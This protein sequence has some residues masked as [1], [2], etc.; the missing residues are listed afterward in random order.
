MQILT[1]NIGA[2]LT[3]IEIVVLPALLLRAKADAF[4]PLRSV[5]QIAHHIY[6]TLLQLFQEITKAAIYI[7]IAPIGIICQ[8]LQIFIAIAGLGLVLPALLIAL[9]KDIAHLD[10][11]GLLSFGLY[12]VWS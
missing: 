11:F 8:L 3:H 7:F 9:V 4:G 6:F 12:S 1:P 5:G 2:V 10:G